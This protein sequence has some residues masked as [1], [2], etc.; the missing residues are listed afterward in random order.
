[1][2]GPP[3]VGTLFGASSEAGGADAGLEGAVPAD[4]TSPA[5]DATGSVCDLQT[6]TWASRLTIDVSWAPQGLMGVI[7][8]PG[9]GRIRQWTKSTRTLRSGGVLDTTVVCGVELP[10]FSGTQI[11]G[12]ETYGVT[13]P[14]AL[15]DDGHLPTFAVSATIRGA[16]AG[17]TYRSDAAA[18]LL[19]LTMADPT[20][21][22]W[23]TPV[24]TVVDSDRDGHPGVTIAMAAGGTYSDAP[25]DGFKT[26]R[27]DHLYVV[28][29]QVTIISA[30][31]MDCDHFSGTVTIPVLSSE[32][33][34]GKYAIDSHVVGCG[35]VNDG[36]ACDPTQTAFVDATQ[37]VFSPS[38]STQFTS[39]RLA[40]GAGCS[41]VR[42]A[43]P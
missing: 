20:T 32:G 29:R 12:A 25:V 19:G 6:G 43:L 26:A 23:P 4:A 24:N 28:I 34:A 35:L 1:V 18:A 8:A 30:V 13:F 5:T 21:D 22:A 42:Q 41:A 10:D 14:D 33:G 39:V 37:P 36:G 3:A 27:A 2:S 15:F 38:G 9:N 31:A 11:A 40:D 17:A 16:G 7:L